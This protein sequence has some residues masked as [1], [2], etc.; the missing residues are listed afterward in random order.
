[1]SIGLGM[2]A[3]GLEHMKDM[4]SGIVLDGAQAMRTSCFKRVGSRSTIL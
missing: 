3:G 4:A 2:E 1:M